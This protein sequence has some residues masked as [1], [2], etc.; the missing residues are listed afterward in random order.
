M[1]DELAVATMQGNAE[2]VRK[3][4]QGGADV[5]YTDGGGVVYAAVH[6]CR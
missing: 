5:N 1:N 4:L 6:R 3:L 2:K